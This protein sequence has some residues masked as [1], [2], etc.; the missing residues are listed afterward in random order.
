MPQSLLEEKTSFLYLLNVTQCLSY[1]SVFLSIEKRKGKTFES[2]T[3]KTYN[4]V[5]GKN[6]WKEKADS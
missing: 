1:T 5:N 6:R 3:R 2:L 4:Q